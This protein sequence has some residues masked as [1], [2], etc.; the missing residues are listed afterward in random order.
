MITMKLNTLLK[1]FGIIL[2]LTCMVI[3]TTVYSQDK[4]EVK[5]VDKNGWLANKIYVEAPKVY[6]IKDITG[7]GII[8]ISDLV[9]MIDYIKKLDAMDIDNNNKIDTMDMNILKDSLFPGK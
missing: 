7:D 3:L 5:E 2:L 4:K 8:D 1:A 9:Y 6:E